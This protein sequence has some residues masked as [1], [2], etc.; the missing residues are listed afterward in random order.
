M[1]DYLVVIRGNGEKSVY[2]TDVAR[3]FVEIGA[4]GSAHGETLS[5]TQATDGWREMHFRPTLE[6][7]L[8]D[9]GRMLPC[10]RC[11]SA[12]DLRLE[13]SGLPDVTHS[14]F[15]ECGAC[16]YW[17]HG[18]STKDAVVRWNTRYQNRLKTIQ[19]PQETPERGL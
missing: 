8:S 13:P 11:G 17:I 14:A 19:K 1:T 3:G 16:G 18:V 5:Y 6:E 2:A 4:D 10:P 12:E 7:A 15:A 9:L